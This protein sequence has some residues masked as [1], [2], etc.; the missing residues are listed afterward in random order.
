METLLTDT[1]F[2]I[3]MVFDHLLPSTQP[4]SSLEWTH[5]SLEQSLA[6]F[7]TTVLEEHLQIALEILEVEICSSF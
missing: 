1:C 6:E 4:Q 2:F 5:T 3:Y 7:Y